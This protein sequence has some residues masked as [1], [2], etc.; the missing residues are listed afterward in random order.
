M[1]SEHPVPHWAPSQS[2]LSVPA[3][4]PAAGPCDPIHLWRNW[5]CVLLISWKA[6]HIADNKRRA[7]RQA[8]R[9]GWVGRSSSQ[10]SLEG[11]RNLMLVKRLRPVP[12]LS[13]VRIL[14]GL[15]SPTAITGFVVAVIVDTIK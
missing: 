8:D 6:L 3:Q 12:K 9:A 1:L 14:L 2:S 4:Q 13:S 7:I 11:T 10:S 5:Q 15:S